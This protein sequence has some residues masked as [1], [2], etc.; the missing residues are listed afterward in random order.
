[1]S[2]NKFIKIC[3]LIFSIILF[4]LFMVSIFV[5][6]HIVITGFIGVELGMFVGFATKDIAVDLVESQY[7]QKSSDEDK[8]E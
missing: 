2:A 5:W 8:G 1:M 6:S 3:S 7:K 4:V